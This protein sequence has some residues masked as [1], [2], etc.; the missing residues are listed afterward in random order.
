MNLIDDL[1]TVISYVAEC[2]NTTGYNVDCL[3]ECLDGVKEQQQEIE[4]LRKALSDILG[5]SGSVSGCFTTT[6][7]IARKALEESR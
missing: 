6:R 4:R 3:M 2:E 1:K 7:D 5:C